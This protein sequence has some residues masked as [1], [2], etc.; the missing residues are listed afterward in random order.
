MGFKNILGIELGTKNIKLVLLK[1]AKKTE[2][3]D[4]VIIKTR[5]NSIVDGQII[6]MDSVV[7]DV[8]TIIAHK[9]IRAKK[10]ALCINSPQ[11]V[12]RQFNIPA[13]KDNEIH[14]AIE[15]ELSKNFPGISE[16]HTISYKIYTRSKENIKGIV[17]VCPNKILE[18]YIEFG[19]RIKIPL[20]YIDVNANCIIKAF[21]SYITSGID[22]G[23][24]IV[25]IGHNSS[26]VNIAEGKEL[27]ISRNVSI[28]GN[29]LDKIISEALKISIQE[30][31][32]DKILKY[33]KYFQQG[34]DIEKYIK[35]AYSVIIEEIR[36]T[37]E[38][39]RKMDNYKEI[40]NI[41]LIGG[42]SLV[43][44]IEK[45]FYSIFKIPTSVIKPSDNN[46]VYIND[47]PR[48]ISAIGVALRED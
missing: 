17:A 12:I 23:I 48:L 35:Q 37:L 2:F 33:K 19:Q 4:K 34:Y 40:S 13:L 28:G 44:D 10:L 14:D 43:S 29:D 32:K 31:E 38:F 6:D 16:T 15:L 20:K 7:E 41:F 46:S 11:T 42:G 47:F 36:Q 27:K 3:L 45:Y 8:N 9:K 24:I 30:A 5:E 39:Y 18:T 1:E 25:D 26:Q 21:N 22:K